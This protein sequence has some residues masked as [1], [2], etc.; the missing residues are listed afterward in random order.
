MLLRV[1]SG[2]VIKILIKASMI[3][4]L[5][6]TAFS[7]YF[8]KLKPPTQLRTSFEG[9]MFDQSSN[10][11]RMIDI[12]GVRI[13]V[14]KFLERVVITK[15]QMKTARHKTMIISPWDIHKRH[16]YDGQGEAKKTAEENHLHGQARAIVLISHQTIGKKTKHRCN[17]KSLYLVWWPWPHQIIE[18]K[19][20]IRQYI[21]LK[22][23][24][25]RFPYHIKV[26]INNE[27]V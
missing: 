21:P 17:G 14:I 4:G 18:T 9:I 11:I 1:S 10:F 23:Q 5:F 16:S 27:N 15:T 13:N 2:E 7:G 19:K 22:I 12:D 26:M 20:H 6:A 3:K 8:Q 24:L 25:Q